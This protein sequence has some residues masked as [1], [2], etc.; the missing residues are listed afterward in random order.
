MLTDR[1]LQIEVLIN[2]PGPHD[3]VRVREPF[4][5]LMA[6]GVDVRLHERPFQFNSC[7]R[8]HSLVIW[9]RPLPENR[10]R[11]WEH[12]QWLRQRGCLLLT[13]WDDHPDLF[14]K[15]V[16]TKLLEMNWAPLVLCHALHTSSTTLATA[17]ESKQPLALVLENTVAE[18]PALNLDKHKHASLKIFIGNQNRGVEHSALLGDLY[19]WLKADDH[20]TL[21]VVGDQAMASSLPK[22]RV[23]FYG[24]L[25]YQQYRQLLG[26]CHIALLPLQRSLQNACKTPIKLLECA[27]ESV[28]TVSGPE[29]YEKQSFHGISVH[30]NHLAD[31]IPLARSLA[32][33]QVERVE[34]TKKAYIWANQIGKLEQSLNYRSWLYSQIWKH[35]HSLDQHVKHRL[36]LEGS[37]SG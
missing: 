21:V 34:L 25:P 15:P 11:Q 10:Q 1:A 27:A 20:L 28:A 29:L 31:I 5:A 32:Q 17:L 24:L 26:Q 22:E 30:A 33:K 13:E 18:I 4:L 3:Q 8:P 2:S 14:P 23:R 16:R 19:E 36:G 7:I 12:L 35:R 37:F 9:Q 6:R